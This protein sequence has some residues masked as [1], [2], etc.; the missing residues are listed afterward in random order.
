MIYEMFYVYIH[1]KELCL[2]VYMEYHSNIEVMTVTG[3]PTYTQM[4]ERVIS[5]ACNL[6]K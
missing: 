5:M 4:R 2:F 1:L 3:M 6:L